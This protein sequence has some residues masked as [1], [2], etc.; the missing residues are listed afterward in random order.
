[1]RIRIY[2]FIEKRVP[3]VWIYVDGKLAG[4]LTLKAY[5][6]LL[7]QKLASLAKEASSKKA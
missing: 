4:H 6:Q 1:M 3:K 2:G 7:N 5:A